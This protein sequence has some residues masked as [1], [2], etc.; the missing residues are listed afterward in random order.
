MKGSTMTKFIVDRLRAG[1][2]G[3]SYKGQKCGLITKEK[4]TWFVSM[5]MGEDENGNPIFNNLPV[6]T[7]KF[8]KFAAKQSCK[9]LYG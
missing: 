1:V 3:F 7:L 5:Y 9:A 2:Y 8:G 4:E 6:P